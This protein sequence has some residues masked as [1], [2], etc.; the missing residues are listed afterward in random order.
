MLQ[1][2]IEQ[3]AMY[4]VFIS[5]DKNAC[6]YLHTSIC[7]YVTLFGDN[8][9]YAFLA[10][11]FG[12]TH[13]Y[14]KGDNEMKKK[15][16]GITLAILLIIVIFIVIYNHQRATNDYEYDSNYV[17]SENI[18]D[19]N[20]VNNLVDESQETIMLSESC[21]IILA[22]GT[23]KNGDFY[24][25]VANQEDTYDSAKIEIG[26]I[27][28]N[29]WL[30]ELTSDMPF[31]DQE[32]YLLNI[33][34]GNVGLNDVIIDGNDSDNIYGTFKYI[35]DGCFCIYPYYEGNALTSVGGGNATDCSIVYNCENGKYYNNKYYTIYSHFY[36]DAAYGNYLLAQDEYNTKEIPL[37]EYKY[38]FYVLNTDT[39][40][41]KLILKGSN[42]PMSGPICDDL[43]LVKNA[44]YDLEGNKVIDL[45]SYNDGDI[46]YNKSYF[47]DGE[48][49]FSTEN[50]AGIHFDVTIDTKG[51]VINSVKQ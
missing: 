23:N 35:A 26:I 45:T 24:E 21:D 25:L 31:I 39:M 46:E 5:I 11:S 50:N 3:I 33:G 15:V 13:F 47:V 51:N 38:D 8:R 14:Y 34:D 16:T 9:S 19:D 30:L 32:T 1:N 29:E 28:N 17:D 18:E 42:E 49:T 48:F 12:C 7:D 22:T 44:F 6:S 20:E 27:K 4:A 36:K 43:F 2:N 40:E 37:R 10:Y 41:I